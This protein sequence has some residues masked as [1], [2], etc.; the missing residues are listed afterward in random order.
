MYFI[1]INSNTDIRKKNSNHH[2]YLH[3][4][5]CI[6]TRPLFN[7][8]HHYYYRS[9]C[10]IKTDDCSCLLLFVHWLILSS[11]VLGWLPWIIIDLVVNVCC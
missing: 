10:L 4:I 3:L 6:T 8:H 7:H 11:F 1:C 9:Y 2:L 5:F